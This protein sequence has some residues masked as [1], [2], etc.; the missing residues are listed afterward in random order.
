MFIFINH[1][2]LLQGSI[3]V[4]KKLQTKINKWHFGP[5]NVHI[6]R[7]SPSGNSKNRLKYDSHWL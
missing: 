2:V 5:L 6:L 4:T 7:V 3:K 1:Q